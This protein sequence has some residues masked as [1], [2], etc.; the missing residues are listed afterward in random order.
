MHQIAIGFYGTHGPVAGNEVTARGLHGLLYNVLGQFDKKRATWLHEHGA[1]KPYTIAPYY[2]SSGRALL[3]IRLTALTEN[4]AAL[5]VPAWQ[6]V[7]MSGRELRLGQQRFT[8]RRMEAVPGAGFVNLAMV[9][10]ANT[11]VLRFLSPT[12]FRQGPGI[13]PLPLPYNVFQRPF[14]IWSSFAPSTL[15][16]PGDWLDWCAKNVFVIKHN[17][18]TE[19]VTISKREPPFLGFVGEVQFEAKD[20][21]ALYLSVLQGLARLAP[22]CGVGRKTTMG[23]GAVERINTDNDWNGR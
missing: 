14:E 22:Y 8:V 19:P 20:D 13:L 6:A 1:P 16:L 9:T 23:M 10:P 11:V 2:D 4:T 12:Q 15:Q 3:G 5:L 7:R 21:A 18:R 17:I